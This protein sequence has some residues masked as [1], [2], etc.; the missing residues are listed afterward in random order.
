MELLQL[1]VYTWVLESNLLLTGFMTLSD[2]FNIS[3]PVFS[4]FELMRITLDNV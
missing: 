2:S 3:V 1:T 4:S